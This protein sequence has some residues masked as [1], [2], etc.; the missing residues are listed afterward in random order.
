M[1]SATPARTAGG[2]TTADVRVRW[3]ADAPAVS[4]T[5]YGLFLEDINFA[6]DGGLN[7]NLVNNWSFDGVYLDRSGGK[8]RFATAVFKK[9]GSGV[10]DPLRHWRVIGGALQDRSTDGAH[11]GARFARLRVN[12]SA[13]VLNDGYPGDVPSMGGRAGVD[14]RFSALVRADAFSGSLGVALVDAAGAVAASAELGR[15]G[16]GWVRIGATL[17]PT[18]TGLYSLQL[19]A[20][21]SGT[22]DLDEVSLIASDHWGAGDPR[23]S[24][25]TLR[26]DLVETLRDLRP[27]FLRFPGGCIVEGVGDGNQYEWKQT[28]GALSSRTPKFNLWGEGRPDGDYSQSNQVGFYEYFL[29]CEDLGMEPVPVVWAGVSCQFRTKECV[30][31][32]SAQFRQVVQDAIDLIDW[33]TGDPST[34]E[35]AALRAEAG[36]P[37]P[38]TLNYIGIGNENHG[39]EYLAHFDAITAAIDEVRPGMRYI[40]ASGAFPK[41]KAFEGS[42]EHARGRSNVILDEHSYAKPDWFIEQATRYDDYP[43]TGTKVMVGEY[44]AHPSYGL[45]VMLGKDRPNTWQSAVAEAA[46]LTGVER[47]V[48]LVDMTCYAPLFALH[49]AKQ[50]RHNMIE[51]TPLLVQPTLNYEVQKL[52]GEAVGR[53]GLRVDVG[54]EGLFASATGDH[55]TAFLKIVN[56]TGQAREITVALD[57]SSPFTAHLL[58][59]HAPV[60]S[61]TEIRDE[62]TAS[63]PLHRSES[64]LGVVNDRLVVR[65]PAG[66]VSRIDLRRTDA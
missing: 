7:A 12:G 25:G 1:T 46:F 38:F 65:L 51:F 55:D 23:W 21:G 56:T 6:A 35:W 42:W 41:G 48:D 9:N 11:D 16:A 3:D 64:D 2:P 32:D 39:P 24:Q 63:T 40:L 30:T 27:R 28:V 45:A 37:E 58:Q 15:P 8:N 18:E 26:R 44:A 17:T 19:T 43:R 13:R 5:L 36:H 47:N 4:E 54:G 60:R 29:L 10:S 49:D 59:L 31:S 66:S 61:H 22:V 33:A 62:L 52:F 57:S 50:W 14:Y 20:Q 53:E 34:S